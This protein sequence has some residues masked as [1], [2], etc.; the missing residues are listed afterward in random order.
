[1]LPQLLAHLR[2]L[3]RE[4][5]PAS[6][7]LFTTE[8]LAPMSPDGFRKLLARIGQSFRARVEALDSRARRAFWTRFYFERGPR[9]VAAGSEAV[10]ETLET[11]LTEGVAATKGFVHLIGAGPGDPE[12]LTMKA[13]RLLH[14]ADLQREALQSAES[15]GGLRLAVDLVLQG[16]GDAAVGTGDAEAHGNLPGKCCLLREKASGHYTGALLCY[17]DP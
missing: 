12:L 3:Q 4:Q 17:F 6:P 2:R 9:A 11:M 7:F 8:R 13:R 5:K 16:G 15:A 1:M 14:E 10:S